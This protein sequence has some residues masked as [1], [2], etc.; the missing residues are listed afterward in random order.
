MDSDHLPEFGQTVSE[1]ES[2]CVYVCVRRGGGRL[3]GELG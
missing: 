3:G 1:L 2:R